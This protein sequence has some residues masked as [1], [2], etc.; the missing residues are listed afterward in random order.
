[1][2]LA[3]FQDHTLFVVIL[4][5][6]YHIRAWRPSGSCDLDHM[7]DGQTTDA[8]AYVCYKLIL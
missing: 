6:V 3:K 5:G 2:L 8:T 7:S 1:M 4:T